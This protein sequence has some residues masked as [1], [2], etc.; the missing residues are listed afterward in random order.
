M[1]P[2]R[3]G[4]PSLSALSGPLFEGWRAAVLCYTDPPKCFQ[5]FEDA[6]EEAKAGSPCWDTQQ[7][8]PTPTWEMRMHPNLLSSG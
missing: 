4:P 2:L 1:S 6:T 8:P 5:E 3:P 7:K